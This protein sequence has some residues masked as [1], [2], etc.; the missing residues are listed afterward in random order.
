MRGR[1]GS[2]SL[3][4]FI[5]ESFIIPSHPLWGSLGGGG[6]CRWY[7]NDPPPPTPPLVHPPRLPVPQYR[8]EASDIDGVIL[9]YFGRSVWLRLGA[10][11]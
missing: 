3:I 7:P 5:D 6:E 1:E 10:D 4:D 8:G 9:I 2:F 11:W